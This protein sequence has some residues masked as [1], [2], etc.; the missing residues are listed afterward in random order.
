[1]I[2]LDKIYCGDAEELIKG[3]DDCTV[4][5]IVTSPPY[6]DLRNYNG[7]CDKCWNIK[8]F[9]AVAVEMA[10]VLK[11]GGILIWNVDDRTENGG[12][13]GTSMRQALY[14][15]D[16]CG[17]KLNDYMFWRKKNPMPQVRQPRYTKRVEFMFC[18]VKGSK[19]KTFN[20]IMIPC[21]SGGKHYRSTGKVI[22][23]ENGRRSLD[24][25]V[26]TE[27]VDYQDWYMSVAQNKRVFKVNSGN[28][29]KHP[30]VFPLELPLRHIRSWTNEG[31]VV[32]DPFI[33]S[34]TTAL[35]AIDLKR[36][37][38]GF[39]MSQD[40]VDIANMLIK[41]KTSADNVK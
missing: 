32:L 40:Y 3:I 7:T 4:D 27:M 6:D 12:K 17:L 41:E 5:L 28:L 38:I 34:G 8:K 31:D 22:G 20:P 21:K 39:E 15:I 33:G 35:A 26:N 19:P 36:H 16:K 14:F 23:G 13:T 1:M 18:F 24:Y 2:E 30:A 25:N 10:R 29:L 37:Y 9:E 11:E